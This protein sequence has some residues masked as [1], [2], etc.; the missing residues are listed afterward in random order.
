MVYGINIAGGY[1]KPPNGQL[2]V[3]IPTR[4]LAE[5][6][7]AEEVAIQDVG[8]LSGVVGPGF[9]TPNASDSSQVIDFQ[10]STISKMDIKAN[11]CQL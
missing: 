2:D 1:A 4:S 5:V 3:W 8:N 6:I 7:G 10:I 9:V 11:L